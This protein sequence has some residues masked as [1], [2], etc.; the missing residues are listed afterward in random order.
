MTI[1]NLCVVRHVLIHLVLTTDA[2]SSE[3]DARRL[4]AQVD[5]SLST[6]LPEVFSR[7]QTRW[8][9]FDQHYDLNAALFIALILI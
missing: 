2:S 8:E 1:L 7:G 3:G 9:K 5:D 4:S 6:N